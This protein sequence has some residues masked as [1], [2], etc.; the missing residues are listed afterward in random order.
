MSLSG[1]ILT[2][3]LALTF[4]PA[5]CGVKN[6]YM[7]AGNPYQ[8][9]A[10]QAEGTWTVPPT[11]SLALTPTS[12]SATQQTF[13]AQI[14]D[15]FGGTDVTTVGV[16]INTTSAAASACAVMYNRAQNTL[17]LLTDAGATPANT[18][19]PGSGTQSNSQCTLSGSGSSASVSGNTLT[20]KAAISFLPVFAGTKNL[21]IE[22]ANSYQSAA[23]TAQGTW[24]LSSLPTVVSGTPVSATATPQTFAFVA[25]DPLGY[26]DISQV[27]FLINATT[28]T[29][30]NSC[31][32]VYYRSLNAIY[33]Y[34]DAQTA[35]MGP[36]TPG[37]ATQRSTE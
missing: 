31:Q 23:W 34:S 9:T 24:T 8:I 35:L 2:L 12:G 4:Q 6:I 19:A 28:S 36:L 14:T 15:S 1:N 17:A 27:Y 33:L 37:A 22:A 30:Q 16:M 25:R 13:T 32:G 7:Q 3:T 18:I 11:L 26:T 29:S 5:F 21:Y 20:L 10:W